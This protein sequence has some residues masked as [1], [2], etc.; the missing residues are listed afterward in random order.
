M[1]ELELSVLE[2]MPVRF[3]R[4]GL[5]AFGELSLFEPLML[6]I[7]GSEQKQKKITWMPAHGRLQERWSLIDP[8]K[9][10]KQSAVKN[11]AR[12]QGLGWQCLQKVVSKHS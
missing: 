3:R 5:S 7:M 11:K 2:R 1:L 12:R 4:W 6:D 9:A 10:G 8:G